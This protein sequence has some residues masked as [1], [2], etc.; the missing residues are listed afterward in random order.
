MNFGKF[1][2]KFGTLCVKICKYK[3]RKYFTKRL[4]GHL[5]TLT[6]SL[7]LS[8]LGKLCKLSSRSV[9]CTIA[10]VTKIMAKTVP[11]IATHLAAMPLQTL[12]KWGIYISMPAQSNEADKCSRIS[13]IY[14]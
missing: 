1:G 12:S 3:P 14:I 9:D 8:S 6:C 13:K 7:F 4:A 11:Q 10:M 2:K 5:K